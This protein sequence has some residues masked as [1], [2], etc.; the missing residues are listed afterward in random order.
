M[1]WMV[2]G[3][4]RGE[5]FDCAQARAEVPAERLVYGMAEAMPFR[6]IIWRAV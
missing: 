6:S 3:K 2:V 5:P 4:K 1:L